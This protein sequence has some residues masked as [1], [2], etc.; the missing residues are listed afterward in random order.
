[1]LIM[2]KAGFLNIKMDVPCIKYICKY[3]YIRV[4]FNC[5][6]VAE[7]KKIYANK[8]IVNHISCVF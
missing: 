2:S 3:L 1:M 8:I 5:K 7:H 4:W 6:A